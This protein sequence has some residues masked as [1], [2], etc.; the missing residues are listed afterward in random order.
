MKFIKLFLSLSF[1][2]GQLSAHPL[3]EA[4]DAMMVT[5]NTLVC[6]GLDPE[7]SRISDE[8]MLDESL[9][10]EERIYSFLTTVVDVT[11]PYI[12]CFKIQKAF[13]DPLENGHIL[14][15]DIVKYIHEKH[16][17]MPVFLDCKI[18]D[19]SNTMRVY[20]QNLFDYMR[21]DGVVIN[22]YMGDDVLEPFMSSPDKVAL[23]LVQ[24]SNPGGDVV[25]EA[26]LANGQ[27]LWRYMLDL[28]LNRWNGNHNLIPIVSSNAHNTNWQEIRAV[29]P[30]DIPMLLAG[31]GAQGGNVTSLVQLLN[32]NKRGVF[33]NSSR[34]IL[35]PYTPD[36]KDWREAIKQATIKLQNQLNELRYVCN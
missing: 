16:P 15:H 30:Q 20:M 29:I 6:C 24:T 5:N 11:A 17:T 9:T 35:Y 28:T 31:I 27:P 36:Q 19:T 2:A 33:V 32:D 14:L 13:F 12:C 23:I 3:F 21:V 18:G 4:L 8:I 7:A 26:L 1:I 10:L 25:Q 22:P 34:D